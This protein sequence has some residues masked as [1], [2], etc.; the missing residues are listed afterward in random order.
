MAKRAIITGITGQDGSYLAELLLDK[1]YEVT[2]IVRRLS[3]PNF[4]RI[5]HL[6]DRITLRPGRSARSAV[7][8]PRHPGRAAARVLQPRGD[9]VRAGVV[10]PAAADRRVQ[11]AGRDAGAR[12][13]PAGRS[14]H[15]ALPGVVERDV[16]AR[17]R[18]AADRADAVL[19]A[20]PVR[21]VEGLRPLHHGELPRELRHV[22]GV[23]HPVQPRVAA[24]RPRVRDAQG[25]RRRRAHQARTRRPPR[26][27][28]PR[29]L[30]RLGFCRRL[31]AGDVAHAAAGHGRRLR[32]CDRRVATRFGSSWKPRSA[33]PASTGRSTSASTPPSCAPPKSII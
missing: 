2:G 9:V 8:D 21:R 28:Q 10:G 23:G 12:G 30:S 3:A 27:R 4:W 18:G 26:P 7:A 20:Q 14:R 13:D 29:C 5:E 22:R 25:D 6:L 15:P 1:G 19:S 11:L 24:P 17:A 31:R 33:T 32:H 16:R